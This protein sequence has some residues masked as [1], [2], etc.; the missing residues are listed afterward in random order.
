[1]SSTGAL[2]GEFEICDVR[3][4]TLGPSRIQFVVARAGRSCRFQ[5]HIPF[6]FEGKR[7]VLFHIFKELPLRSVFWF[8]TA[9]GLSE[10]NKI[11]TPPP[12]HFSA[13]VEAT[14]TKSRTATNCHY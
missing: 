8:A 4:F 9:R 12:N 5:R 14:V 13:R 3:M 6:G 11:A 2:T 10:S 7:E 1:M